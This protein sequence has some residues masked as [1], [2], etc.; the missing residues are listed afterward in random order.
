MRFMHHNI[1]N[2]AF[3]FIYAVQLEV[4]SGSILDVRLR[5]ARTNLPK[6]WEYPAFQLEI[7]GSQATLT[8]HRPSNWPRIELDIVAPEATSLGIALVRMSPKSD[9]QIRAELAHKSIAFLGLARNCENAV[10]SAVGAFH[11]LRGMFGSSSVHICENDSTDATPLQLQ[12][13]SEQGV[14]TLHTFKALDSKL[15]KRTERLAYLRNY[16]NDLAASIPNL[17]YVCWL[18]MDSYVDEQFSEDGFLTCFNYVEAWDAVFPVMD[19]FY[20]DVWALRHKTMWPED[21]MSEI[22]STWDLALGSRVASQAPVLVRQISAH[23][24][25]GW[26][27][28]DSAFGGMAIYKIKACR[29]GRYVGIMDGKEVCEHVAFNQSIGANGG[30]LWINPSF[31]VKSPLG[32][33]SPF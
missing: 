6:N 7:R 17:D 21:C 18:D 13:L 26:M 23:H 29:S 9:A 20:Y 11:K 1:N 5:T 16:L 3:D 22:N 12:V 10:V 28:V 19:G 2:S 14:I 8:F 30:R 24:M 27:P 4:S 32:I 25:E 33:A 15:P 31:R